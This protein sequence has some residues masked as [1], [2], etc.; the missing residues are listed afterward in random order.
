LNLLLAVAVAFLVAWFAWGTAKNVR[1]GNAV[2]RWMQAGLP[3]LGAKTTIRWLGSTA[4][5]M[6]LQEAKPPFEQVALVIFLEPR[7]MPWLWALA[8][9]RGRKDTLIVRAKLRRQPRAELELIDRATWS[10]R[11]ALPRLRDWAVREPA[12]A[13]EP[14]LY[15]RDQAG[16][17]LADDLLELARRE[18]LAP[19]RLAVRQ[20]EPH[21]QLHLSLPSAQ[22][23]AQRFFAALR[24]LGEHA[25]A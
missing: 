24:V 9:W 18:A 19:W 25:A 16:Q 14:A 5:E 6:R 3:L 22:A 21:F 10:G 23:D 7:D 15:H 2:M 4:V 12:S 13:A 20:G 11:E 8:R 17:S 1:R